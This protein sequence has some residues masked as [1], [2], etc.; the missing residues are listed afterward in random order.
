V[1]AGCASSE[2]A[3]FLQDA[4]LELMAQRGSYFDPN[5]RVLHNYLDNPASSHSTSG[6][7]PHSKK[8]S[9][10]STLCGAPARIT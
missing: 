1:L 9:R 7:W 8:G 5:L 4:T 2:H 6:H 3:T 10:R